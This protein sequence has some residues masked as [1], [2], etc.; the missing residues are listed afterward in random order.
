M[1]YACWKIFTHL[2]AYLS[3]FKPFAR[4]TENFNRVQFVL[5]GLFPSKPEFE[6]KIAQIFIKKR[7]RKAVH[8][9]EIRIKVGTKIFFI[10]ES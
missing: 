3:P 9:S 2:F 8:K 1:L 4:A 10:Q 5:S 7:E 6:I